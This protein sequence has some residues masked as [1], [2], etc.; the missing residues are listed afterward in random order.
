MRATVRTRSRPFAQTARLQR[1]RSKRT[2]ACEPERT[3]NLAILATPRSGARPFRRGLIARADVDLKRPG[4][5]GRRLSPVA[6]CP[7]RVCVTTSRLD[8]SFSEKVTKS[9]GPD[10]VALLLVQPDR[11]LER[12]SGFL[13][14]I[15]E[16][17]DFAEIGE[18]LRS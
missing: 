3:P 17:Q 14:A 11:L 15:R 9:L 6:P 8:G 12:R 10:H 13:R 4:V 1:F 16:A 18:G 2:N 5:E 7:E